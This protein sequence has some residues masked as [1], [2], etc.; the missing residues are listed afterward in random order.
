MGFLNSAKD[1]ADPSVT[2]LAHFNINPTADRAA[3]V[4]RAFRATQKPAAA[5]KPDPK[6]PPKPSLE[7]LAT[8]APGTSATPA[9]TEKVFTRARYDEL[10]ALM[11]SPRKLSDKPMDPKVVQE[12]RD[13]TAAA[14]AGKLSG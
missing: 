10:S 12:W 9:P 13:Y 8:P 4:F 11:M 14:R 5:P 2:W 3:A 1:A 6:E 7:S